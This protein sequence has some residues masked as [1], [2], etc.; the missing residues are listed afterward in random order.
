MRIVLRDGEH[1]QIVRENNPGAGIVSVEA[2]EG[3]YRLGVTCSAPVD[4]NIAP[5]PGLVIADLGKPSGRIEVL[6][7]V[8]NIGKWE[9]QRS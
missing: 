7:S 4:L 5:Q 1:V 3:S 8:A 9:D 6:G 2:V